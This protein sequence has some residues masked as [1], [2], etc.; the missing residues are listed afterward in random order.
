MDLVEWEGYP[1][2][3]ATCEPKEHVTLYLITEYDVP[4]VSDVGLTHPEK[5]AGVQKFS[6]SSNVPSVCLPEKFW[7]KE[8][9]CGHADFNV[10]PGGGV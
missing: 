1:L 8:W 9:S 4:P 6:R 2:S 3:S 7:S 10:I 5:N